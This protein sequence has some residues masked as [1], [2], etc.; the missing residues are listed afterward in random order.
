MLTE[1]FNKPE[2]LT[3]AFLS[4]TEIVINGVVYT[5]HDFWTMLDSLTAALEFP[6][7][8]HFVVS[9]FESAREY[10]PKPGDVLFTPKECF[11]QIVKFHSLFMEAERNPMDKVV[12]KAKVSLRDMKDALYP[13]ENEVVIGDRRFTFK[14]G[15]EMYD[16]IGRALRR[17]NV[18][19]GTFISNY[20]K[21]EKY[22]PNASEELKTLTEMYKSALK[23]VTFKPVTD[24]FE[25]DVGLSPKKFFMASEINSIAESVS[26]GYILCDTNDEK[27]IYYSFLNELTTDSVLFGL[28]E[29]GDAMKLAENFFHCYLLFIKKH[30]PDS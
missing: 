28:L 20:K 22:I 14:N 2:L 30:K 23:K 10:L 24:Y 16:E 7:R 27:D 3:L 15:E 9:G 8:K 1:M 21:E 4:L 11:G 17:Y 25:V 18:I 19:D 13:S 26:R 12:N 29:F 5:F 6:E